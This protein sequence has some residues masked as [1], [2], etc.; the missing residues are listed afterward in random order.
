MAATVGF[1]GQR[2]VWP[3]DFKRRALAEAETPGASIRSV[4]QR[5]GLDK[6]QLYQWRKKH[7]AAMA[8]PTAAEYVF[9]PVEI[10]PAD[11]CTPS[12]QSGNDRAEIMF[13]NGR[14]LFISLLLERPQLDRLIA[15]VASS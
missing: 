8:H 5:Y 6:S 7:R 2:R 14:R 12:Y 15:A 4:A 1:S 13:P 9:L 10:T 3:E 11:A